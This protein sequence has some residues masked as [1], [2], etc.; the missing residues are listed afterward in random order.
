MLSV[1]SLGLGGADEELASG[2]ISCSEVASLAHDPRD[3][4]VE[5]RS[6]VVERL[7][8]VTG[9]FL[10]SSE[11]PEV[12]NGVGNHIGVELHDDTVGRL[13]AD[14]HVKEDLRVGSH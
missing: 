6:L 10:T 12:L 5:R 9:T 7:V 4:V 2:A 3:H 1:E 11:S 13:V 14:G 8:R